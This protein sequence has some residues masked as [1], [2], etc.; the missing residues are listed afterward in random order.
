MLNKTISTVVLGSCL[1]TSSFAASFWNKYSPIQNHHNP[2][3][4]AQKNNIKQKYTDFSGTWSGSCSADDEITTLVISNDDKSIELDGQSYGIGQMISE[5]S[6][7]K[8]FSSNTQLL[9]TWNAA[10]TVLKGQSVFAATSWVDGPKLDLMAGIFE[11]TF[12]MNGNELVLNINLV[13]TD[14]TPIPGNENKCTFHK[15]S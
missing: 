7:D 8:S 5:S 12:K 1:I 9:L 10:G 3:V 13:N 4:T 11:T 15:V 2:S 6:S 14:G